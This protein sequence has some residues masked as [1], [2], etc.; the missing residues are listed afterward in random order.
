[1]REPPDDIAGY[2]PTKHPSGCEW[3]GDRAQLAVDFFEEVLT[4][5][6]D[7]PTTRAG[8][9]FLLQDW[10]KKYIATLFGWLRPDGTRRYVESL[11][12]VPRKNGKTALAAGIA[13]FGLWA[14]HRA[15][16]QVYSAAMDR[17]QASA[18]YRTAYQMVMQSETLRND[19]KCVDSTKRITFRETG[20]FYEALSG[21]ADSGHSKK[22][23]YVLFDELHTQRN[24]KLYD[25][26]Q[27]GFGSTVG[28]LLIAITTAGW[29]RHSICWELWQTARRIRDNHGKD[30]PYFLPMIY[31][32][33]EKE[34]WQDER[35]WQRCNPNL[36]VSIDIEFLREEFLKAKQSPAFENTFRNL[37][38]NQWVEQAVRWLPMDLWDSSGDAL[39]DMEGEPCWLGVDLSATT[40]L[41][42][43]VLAFCLGDGRF[44]VIPHFWIPEDTARAAENRDRVPYRLW[45]KEGFVTMTPGRQVEHQYL[46]D[47]INS[48][49][50]KYQLLEVVFDRWGS[51]ALNKYLEDHGIERAQFGQGYASM[52][53]PS[54]E[55]EKLVI[56][57]NLLHGGNPV[58]RWNASN[59]AITR[60]AADNIKPVK[61]K[62][63]GRIDGIIAA[64]MA[65]SRA[66]AGE[67]QGYWTKAD[68]V[69]L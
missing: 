23:F 27:T 46:F 28:R 35:T 41:T 59:V 29:D 50:E 56:S 18:I 32:L 57:G 16:S 44:A 60:D 58:L 9:P 61:D 26:L 5:P 62:S 4:H 45:A 31:E 66:M 17:D 51:L 67:S 43:A 39:P 63:T 25:N 22:P 8:D 64:I 20:G 37:Y 21:D 53:A 7:S 47:Y 13:L 54:K 65:V 11:A 12:A 24:R 38:L 48:L 10:Q 15:S 3:N 14:E 34:D 68:G 36:G 69:T 49:N 42:A 30:N 6:D 40:D 2:D 52:S 1:M 33:G 55:F 19:L